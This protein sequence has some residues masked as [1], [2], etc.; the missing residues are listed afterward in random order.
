MVIFWGISTCGQVDVVPKRFSVATEFFHIMYFPLLPVRS[1]VIFDQ[2]PPE[3]ASEVTPPAEGT[4]EAPAAA[5]EAANAPAEKEIRIRIPMSGKSVLLGYLR[6]WG[7]WLAVVCGFL[8]GMLWLMSGSD[9]EAAAMY[10]GFLWVALGGFIVAMASYYGP[11]NT[12]SPARAL[13]LCKAAGLDPA[14]LPDE[15]RQ[16]AADR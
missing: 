3:D 13:G 8:G 4:Q 7:F 6:G 16:A 11:W 14:V 5:P 10:P 12:A 9:P 1:C 2:R 15:L